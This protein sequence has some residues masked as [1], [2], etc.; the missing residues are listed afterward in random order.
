MP[1]AAK[2]MRSS[3]SSSNWLALRSRRRQQL[4]GYSARGGSL[5]GPSCLPPGQLQQGPLGRCPVPPLPAFRRRGARCGCGRVRGRRDL[6][7]AQHQQQQQLPHTEALV[8]HQQR[9]WQQQ[10]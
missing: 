6:R 8:Q 5:M 7:E 2:Y 4:V 1:L 9:P 3:G 10:L